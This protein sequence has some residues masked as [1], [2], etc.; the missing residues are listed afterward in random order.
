M[1]D[2]RLALL[3]DVQRLLLG[4]LAGIGLA[5]AIVLVAVFSGGSEP[6]AV[7]G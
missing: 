3:L 4:A 2:R 1:D 6:A 5:T 7:A